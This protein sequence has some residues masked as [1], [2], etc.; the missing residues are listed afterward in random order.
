[1]QSSFSVIA[2]WKINALSK[3]L[4]I[5]QINYYNKSVAAPFMT[6]S[7]CIVIGSRYTN[8]VITAAEHSSCYSAIPISAA[9][10]P[11]LWYLKN[12]VEDG[13]FHVL[14]VTFT[15]WNRSS[16]GKVLPTN[17]WR[18][19]HRDWNCPG[20]TNHRQYLRHTPW[21]WS[22]PKLCVEDNKDLL[23]IYNE[24]SG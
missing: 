2:E 15:N 8:Q 19:K 9:Q 10:N 5:C 18:E 6:H 20:H 13:I 14:H 1:M 4:H 3:L 21:S 23:K 7:Q 22:E 11:K 12:T 16:S 24:L 17:D